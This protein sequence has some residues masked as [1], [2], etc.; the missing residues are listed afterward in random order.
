MGQGGPAAATYPGIRDSTNLS[1]THGRLFP[2]RADWDRHVGMHA[3]EIETSILLHAAL[4]LI[5][6]GSSEA[7]HNGDPRPFP[8]VQEMATYTKSGVIGFPTRS[9]AEK[10]RLC[11][12]V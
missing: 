9:A 10:G 3:G 7:D 1:T 8:L 6:K 11:S 5:R 12:P 2:L 4:K